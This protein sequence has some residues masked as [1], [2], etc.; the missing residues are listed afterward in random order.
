M[1][2]QRID[3]HSAQRGQAAALG[4]IVGRVHEQLGG[5]ETRPGAWRIPAGGV[6]FVGM[7]ASYAASMLAVT[8]LLAAGIAARREIA[9][10]MPSDAGAC[11]GALGFGIS[12][13]GRSPETVEALSRFAE[14]DRRVVVN[15]AE[16]ALTE[17]A[18]HTIDLGSEQDSYASTIGYTGTLV[19]LAMIADRLLG[20][21]PDECAAAWGDIEATVRAF[22][23]VTAPIVGDIANS[24]ARV[25]SADVVASG[26][27]RAAAESGALLLREVC[28]IPSS[29]LVTRNYLHGEMESAGDTLHLILGDG[30]EHQLARQLAKAGHLTVLVTSQTAAATSAHLAKAPSTLRVIPLPAVDAR[31]RVVLETIVLQQLAGDLADARG[32]SIEDF[33]FEHDDTKIGGMV[34]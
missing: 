16:S 6:V 8:R 21:T 24:A 1:A 30:R 12:Q 2:S 5:D 13:S 27:S 19:G 4:R 3:Y 29:A 18:P 11:T 7:G 9:S 22:E 15:V 10:E 33:V 34:Q 32:I 14:A 25:R 17:I 23:S 31:V 26:A 20:A 28:R